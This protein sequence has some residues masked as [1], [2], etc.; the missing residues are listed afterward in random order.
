MRSQ[1]PKGTY[2]GGSMK[3][4]PLI[5]MVMSGV[6]AIGQPAWDDQL[7]H[8]DIEHRLATESITHKSRLSQFLRKK[9]QR[10]MPTHNIQL[11]ELESGLMGIF[12][13]GNFHYGEVAGYRASKALGLRLVPPT[14]FR[15]INGVQGSFQFF[16]SAPC[17][18]GKPKSRLK[19]VGYKAISDMAL[20]YYI[21]GQSDTHSGNQVVASHNGRYYLGLIDNS[22]MIQILYDRYGKSPFSIKGSNY[23][24]LSE[25]GTKFPFHKVN[26]LSSSKARKVFKAYASHGRLSKILLFPT[27]RYVIWNHKLWIRKRHKE[28]RFTKT[29]YRST[30][31]ALKRLTAEE[32]EDIWYEFSLI[33]KERG[34]LLVKLTL[35]RRDEV[36]RYAD[37]KG[38]IFED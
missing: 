18:E 33:D 25:T 7:D 38:T 5:F 37:E 31:E 28:K 21:F 13:T 6:Q 10:V 27:V 1:I 17:L 20:F 32:L 14:V 15:T 9:G 35:E 12:K 3:Y 19:K 23:D 11:I 36:L 26:S 4:I 2:E 34:G 24:L 30:L 16:I 29:F 8:E 22:L